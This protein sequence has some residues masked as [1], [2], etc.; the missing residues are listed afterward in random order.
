[1]VE[2]VSRTATI[3]ALASLANRPFEAREIAT[4]AAPTKR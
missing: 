1:M 4:N 2:T 3:D